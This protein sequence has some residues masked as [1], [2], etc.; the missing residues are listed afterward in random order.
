ML[1]LSLLLWCCPLPATYLIC[2]ANLDG[3]QKQELFD[4]I[5][6]KEPPRSFFDPASEEFPERSLR[7]AWIPPSLWQL[8]ML[9]AFFSAPT[10]QEG[11]LLCLGSEGWEPLAYDA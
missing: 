5:L 6:R 1:L 8:G 7:C 10:I 3:K 9:H 2:D 11:V 4:L